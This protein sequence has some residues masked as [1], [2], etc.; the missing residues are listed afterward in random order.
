MTRLKSLKR[1]SHNIGFIE[2]SSE[3]IS[4]SLKQPELKNG[5]FR[6]FRRENVEITKFEL[7]FDVE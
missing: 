3:L 7:C 5:S 6:K 2:T 4:H 1:L